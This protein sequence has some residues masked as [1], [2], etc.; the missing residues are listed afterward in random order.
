[1]EKERKK[2]AIIGVGLACVVGASGIGV[3]LGLQDDTPKKKSADPKQVQA[4]KQKNPYSKKKQTKS[5]PFDRKEE[6]GAEKE[7]ASLFDSEQIKTGS[8]YSSSSNLVAS[9]QVDNEKQAALQSL[10]QKINEAQKKKV[11]A[12]ALPDIKTPSVGNGSQDNQVIGQQVNHN[13]G[14]N[15]S[16][17][18]PIPTPNPTPKPTPTPAPNPAPNPTPDPTPEPDPNETQQVSLSVPAEVTIHVL[19]SFNILDYAS[20]TDEGGK[21]ISQNIQIEQDVDTQALGDQTITVRATNG[22]A[23]VRTN[24]VIHVINDAPEFSKLED[25]EVEV[26][27]DYNPY[28][29]VKA[30]DTEEGDLTAKIHVDN[31]VDT[32]KPG[33]YEVTY[34]VEDSFGAQTTKNIKVKVIAQSPSFEGVEDLK[35]SK[36][37]VFDPKEGVSVQD[38]YGEVTYTVEGKVDTDVPGEY[39]VTYTAKN[40]YDQ[41]T[42]IERKITVTETKD[43]E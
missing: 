9:E 33:I 1:M 18:K 2:K 34:T 32:T 37:T 43:Q 24:I 6:Q 41:E 7:L 17:I 19:S 12:S 31:Q 10:E 38:K 29:D 11:L 36:G 35:I 22:N 3:A 39:I 15:H 4:D 8:P 30:T 5:S 42:K 13:N 25:Q 20:A 16:E 40:K 14:N 26:E 28:L 21:D 23:I 27:T